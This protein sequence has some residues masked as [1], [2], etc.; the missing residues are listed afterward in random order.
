MIKNSPKSTKFQ[1][2]LSF[3]MF[4]SWHSFCNNEPFIGVFNINKGIKFKIHQNS[5]FKIYQQTNQVPYV[6]NKLHKLK[7]KIKKIPCEGRIKYQYILLRQCE[8][9]FEWLKKGQNNTIKGKNWEFCFFQF[10]LAH[11]RQGL[12]NN[13]IV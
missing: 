7:I 10:P 5:K 13:S 8:C 12:H 6:E 4:C 11:S 1:H 3:I 9:V 2:S